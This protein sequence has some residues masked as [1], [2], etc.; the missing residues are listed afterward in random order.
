MRGLCS[1]CNYYFQLLKEAGS[2]DDETS[3]LDTSIDDVIEFIGDTLPAL[4]ATMQ[5]S[6]RPDGSQS[7]KI[8][9]SVL[10]M[11][12]RV[13]EWAKGKEKFEVIYQAQIIF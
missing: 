13:V 11:L 12:E 1:A 3:E 2:C 8:P 6:S 9:F 5:K 7:P 10:Q 4:L